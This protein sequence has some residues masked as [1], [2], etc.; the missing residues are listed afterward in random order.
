MISRPRLKLIAKASSLRG[1]KP[2]KRKITYDEYKHCGVDYSDV[3]QAE[4][5]D[6][7]HQKFR[8]YKKEVS[9]FIRDIGD[10]GLTDTKNLTLIAMGCGT[11]ATVIHASKAFRKIYAVDVS[12]VMIQQAV[13]KAERENIAHSISCFLLRNDMSQPGNQ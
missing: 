2:F 3:K 10:L 4:I 12:D 7:Q 9:D 13:Q 8:N 6:E 1:M 11:G 5:Y